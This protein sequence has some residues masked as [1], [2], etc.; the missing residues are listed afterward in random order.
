MIN[1]YRVSVDSNM[2]LDVERY[3]SRDENDTPADTIVE[4]KELKKSSERIH[5]VTE[6]TSKALIHDKNPFQQ[7]CNNIYVVK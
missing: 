4:P 5:L 6:F 3:F 2:G 7:L 1:T